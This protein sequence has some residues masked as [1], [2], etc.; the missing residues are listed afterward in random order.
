MR[1]LD[2]ITY[3]RVQGHCL[4]HDI[5]NKK[6][7][8]FTHVKRIYEKCMKHNSAGIN[9]DVILYHGMDIGTL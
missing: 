3:Y 5:Q 8:Y 2:A 7:V 9:I 1:V 4:I 6:R